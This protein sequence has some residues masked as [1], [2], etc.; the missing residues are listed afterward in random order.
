MVDKGLEST[1]KAIL[2]WSQE[3]Q[4]NLHFIDPGNP[5][6]KA[7]IESLNGRLREEYLNQHWFRDLYDV[8]TIIADWRRN[9]NQER[10]HSSLK[11]LISRA[12]K[13]VYDK[14]TVNLK[15]SLRLV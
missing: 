11:Q 3:N 2:D 4:V 10:P 13:Q 7:Y 1:S 8:R 6:K 12:I 14:K 5:V 15:P 9:N